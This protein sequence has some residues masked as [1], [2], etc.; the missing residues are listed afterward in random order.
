MRKARTK[1][2]KREPVLFAALVAAIVTA[3]FPVEGRSAVVGSDVKT[4]R[5]S[6]A[7]YGRDL[8]VW[9]CL[10]TGEVKI[11]EDEAGMRRLASKT[12]LFVEVDVPEFGSLG[13]PDPVPEKFHGT[14]NLGVVG[15]IDFA[16]TKTLPPVKEWAEELTPGKD[17]QGYVFVVKT[18]KE[19]CYLV[20]IA[21]CSKGDMTLEY[22][23]LD[24]GRR[25]T[26]ADKV[27]GATR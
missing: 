5:I 12:D 10:D 15:A 3:S 1:H 25:T 14:K 20:R 8:M 22:K 11:P 27:P 18:R 16:A 9:I 26:G 6:A 21:S 2:M 13:W 17:S 19:T 24:Q 7:Q 23:T 4:L